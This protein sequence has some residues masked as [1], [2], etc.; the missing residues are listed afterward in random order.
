[1]ASDAEI[2]QWTS[3]VGIHLPDATVKGVLREARGLLVHVPCKQVT[4]DDIQRYE[5]MLLRAGATGWSWSSDSS[6]T[7]MRVRFGA[8]W[9]PWHIC[10][11]LLTAAGLGALA[12]LM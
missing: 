1:M 4:A 5:M 7:A 2:Q 10:L 8:K 6:G 12:W 3:T 9:T 11:A